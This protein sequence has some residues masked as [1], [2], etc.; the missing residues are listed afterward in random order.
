MGQLLQRVGQCG[1]TVHARPA[2][3]RSLALKITHDPTHFGEWTP[4]S[5]QQCHHAGPDRRSMLTSC[6]FGQRHGQRLSGT[7]PST[8]VATEEYSPYLGGI[9]GAESQ[10]LAKPSTQGCFDDPRLRPP[11]GDRQER[12]PR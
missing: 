2:L 7:D 5:R 4:V 11:A 3:A 12:G 1:Q 6:L 10:D 9:D 8:A